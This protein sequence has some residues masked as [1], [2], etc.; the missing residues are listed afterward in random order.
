MVDFLLS[1]DLLSPL[2]DHKKLMTMGHSRGGKTALWHGVQDERVAITYPLMSGCSGNGA[3]R[4][5]TPDGP[6]GSIPNGGD[7][8]AESLLDINQHFPYWFSKTYHNFSNAKNASSDAQSNI[9]WD[10]HFQRALIAPRAQFGVEGIGNTHENPVGSQA[11]YVAAKE[12]YTWFHAPEKIGTLFHQCGH[13]MN[14]NTTH[15][16]GSHEHDWRTCVDFAEFIFDGKRPANK[17]LFDT[18]PYPVQRPYSWK[19]PSL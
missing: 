5:T 10:Q 2:T 11:T 1:D 13:P 12:V 16:D 15:C 17:S 14:D 3:I 7:G 19:A 6:N 18:L 4:I 8:S 9:P